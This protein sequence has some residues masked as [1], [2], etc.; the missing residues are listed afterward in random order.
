MAYIDD[1]QNLQKK[2]CSFESVNYNNENCDNTEQAGIRHVILVPASYNDTLVAA[3]KLATNESEYRVAWD[4]A[5]SAKAIVMSN[6]QGSYPGAEFTEATGYGDA[7][8]KVTGAKHNIVWKDDTVVGNEDFNDN[9]HN[10]TNYVV[11]YAT[12]N[13]IWDTKKV[14]TILVKSVTGENKDEIV[15]NEYSAKSNQ[16]KLHRS[17]PRPNYLFTNKTGGI[18]IPET[19]SVTGPLAGS[20]INEETT[21]TVTVSL[22]NSCTTDPIFDVTAFSNNDLLYFQ[23]DDSTDNGDGTWNLQLE[24]DGVFDV[25]AE[26]ELKIIMNSCGT[27]Y[28]SNEMLVTI[29]A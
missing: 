5:I 21:F 25:G 18:T 2:D 7:D 24:F 13:Y 28:S 8:S 4:N 27:I 23:V 20:T 11:W 9:L 6:V 16:P 15:Y 19:A 22:P 3:L 10:S 17:Y 14:S 1:F 29:V 12:G 26:I